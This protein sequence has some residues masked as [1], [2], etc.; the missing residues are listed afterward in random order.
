MR[1][2]WWASIDAVKS[3][4]S[5]LTLIFSVFGIIAALVGAAAWFTSERLSVLEGKNTDALHDRVQ[6]AE[7]D[8]VSQHNEGE[9][10]RE[11][12]KATEASLTEAQQQLQSVAEAQKPRSISEDTRLRLLQDLI[13][14]PKGPVSVTAIANKEAEDFAGPICRI[15]QGAGWNPGQVNMLT[16][17]GLPSGVSIR[18]RD[19][20]HVPKHA[21]GIQ[22]AMVAAGISAQGLV[23]LHIPEGTLDILVG[24]KP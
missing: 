9:R 18:I 10:L 11:R 6:V 22:H 19:P 14:I 4:N 21:R 20:N 15:F 17:P 24:A 12:L 7:D 8:V 3:A 16:M 1:I 13:Q 2:D 23:D 5:W